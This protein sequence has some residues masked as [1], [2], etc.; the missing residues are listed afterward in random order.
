MRT[1]A[2][3]CCG[4]VVLIW[5]CWPGDS[6]DETMRAALCGRTVR[7]RLQKLSH[8]GICARYF[9]EYVQKIV[10]PEILVVSVDKIHYTKEMGAQVDALCAARRFPMLLYLPGG[11]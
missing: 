8:H 3:G 2:F 5:R 11:M 4:R 6:T 9:S 7:P 10:K 1:A